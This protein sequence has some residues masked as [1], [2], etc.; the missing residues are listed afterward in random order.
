MTTYR[1]QIVTPQGILEDG[2]ISIEADRITE[3]RPAQPT[4]ALET[5]SA[6]I[7]P[8]FVDVHNHGGAGEGFPTS[9]LEGCRKAARHHRAHGST[10]LLASL[11]S[12]SGDHLANQTALLAD[13]ADQGE[14]DGVHMEGPFVNTLRCGA[15]DPAAIIPG[16][17]MLLARVARAGRGWLKTVTFAPETD[18]ALELI[19]VCAEHGIVASLGHTDADFDTTIRVLAHAERMGVTA[20]ATHLFNAMPQI[21]HRA[22]GAAAAMIDAAATRRMIVELVADGVHLHDRT[23]DLIWDTVGCE[24]AVF[25][26]DSMAAAGMS[27]GAYV[28]GD[29]AVTVS[30]GIARLT[31][32][33]GTVGAIAGGT[34][35]LSDQ[36]RR[37]VQRGRS[38]EEAVVMAATTG[39]KLLNYSDRG[40]LAIGN[41]ADVIFTNNDLRPVKV[42][43]C[44]VETPADPAIT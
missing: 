6:W 12:A 26:T 41:R 38:I 44:G 32:S 42:L 23:V 29:L 43:H 24:Q 4:D 19:D 14:I 27:D 40:A 22:P 5:T 1:G 34:S 18:H 33:D 16:D 36:V 2:I 3:L 9:D 31:T 21:H 17:P 30:Q 28:L 39:A 10:T 25:V 13:L 8:G 37:H 7:L 35:R 11:V 20:T 15:Q